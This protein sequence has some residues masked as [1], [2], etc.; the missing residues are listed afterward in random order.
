MIKIEEKKIWCYYLNIQHSEVVCSFYIRIGRSTAKNPQLKKI[1]RY[2]LNRNVE[3]VHGIDGN[4][5]VVI[6]DI[7]FKG[8]R[9]IDWDDVKDYLKEYVGEF[10]QI[11]DT[12]D[13]IYIGKEMPDE[14]TSSKYTRSLKGA[15]AK[16]KANAAQGI[17]ELIC[18]SSGVTVQDNLNEKH[19]YD[20]KYGWYRYDS[21]FAIPIYDENGNVERYNVF[22]CRMI[23]RHDANGKKYLYD[24]INIKKEPSN[25]LSLL[26]TVKNPVP[27]RE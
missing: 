9:K 7:R 14:Y 23:I 24:I 22:R 5:I 10:Y 8:K 11:V 17:P 26:H 19:K 3:I 4:K 25:P 21:R 2:I 15:Y 13:I 18:I 20:A 1:R 12:K 6:Y 16:V 27:C